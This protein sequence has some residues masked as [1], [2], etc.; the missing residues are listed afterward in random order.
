MLTAN[1]LWVGAYGGPEPMNMNMM[2]FIPFHWVFERE[3]KKEEKKRKEKRRNC[4]K[5]TVFYLLS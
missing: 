4:G 2:V 1:D 5:S 3:E